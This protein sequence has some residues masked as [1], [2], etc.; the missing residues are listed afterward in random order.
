M[1]IRFAYGE[2][3]CGISVD[4]GDKGG[5]GEIG[6]EATVIVQARDDDG[7]GWEHGYGVGMQPWREVDV[8]TVDQMW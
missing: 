6:E 5:G 2:D 7:P 8:G 3:P 1:T 4:N